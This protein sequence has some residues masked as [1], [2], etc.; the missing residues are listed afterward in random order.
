MSRENGEVVRRMYDAYARGDF[1]LSLS[2][3]DPEVEF[4]QPAG[5]PGAGTYHGHEGV[6]KR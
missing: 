3:M 6:Y 5:E 2:C 1:E 4:S